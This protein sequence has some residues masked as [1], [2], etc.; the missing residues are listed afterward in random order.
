M[1]SH[2]EHLKIRNNLDTLRRIKVLDLEI[3]DSAMKVLAVC[4]SSESQMTSS[5]KK[6][7]NLLMTRADDSTVEHFNVAS[8]V[9]E[10]RSYEQ[11]MPNMQKASHPDILKNS[12]GMEFVLIK[13]GEFIMGSPGNEEGR[14][15]DEKEKKIKISKDFYLQNTP[16]TVDQWKKFADDRHYT[17]IAEK[18]NAGAYVF[19]WERRNKDWNQIQK[20]G[21]NWKNPGFKQNGD[22]PVTCISFTD[23][24]EFIKWLNHKE[25]K[26]YRLPKEAEWEYSCRAGTPF[27]FCFGYTLLKDMANFGPRESFENLDDKNEMYKERTTPIK[28]FKANEWGLYDMHGNVWEWCEDA[29]KRQQYRIIRGG[30]WLFDDK[31]CRSANRDEQDEDSGNFNIGFRLVM[32]I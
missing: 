25:K 11:N 28:Q 31:V 32:E 23:A 22:H 6:Q 8:F 17:T 7:Y 18:N 3:F 1:Y 21:I 10:W 12:V 14:K 30:S 5:Q 26:I 20:K 16:V 15:D 4:E 24:K 19:V 13:S 27:P 9:K 2:S 29:G